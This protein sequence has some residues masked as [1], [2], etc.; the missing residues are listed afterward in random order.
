[1][2]Y[3]MR[4]RS[5]CCVLRPLVALAFLAALLAPVAVAQVPA[6]DFQVHA[7]SVDVIPLL[8]DVGSATVTVPWTYTYQPP[9]QASAAAASSL[10]LHWESP[11]CDAPGMIVTGSLSQV[12]S[13]NATP[14]PQS[15]SGESLFRVRASQDAPGERDITC[16]FEG[17][18][19]ANGVVPQSPPSGAEATVGVAF[20]GLLA[21]S[22]PV[23]ILEGGP[24]R[25][26]EYEVQVTNLGNSLTEARFEVVGEADGWVPI[27]PTRL[28]LESAN[29]NSP[30]K[31]PQTSAVVL[32][33]VQTPYNEGWNNRE[34]A[35]QLK[36][37]PASTRDPEQQGPPTTVNA[38]ARVRGFYC[39]TQET[40][41]GV[42]RQLRDECPAGRET[43]CEEAL[44]SLD[45]LAAE[46]VYTRSSPGAGLAF[47]GCLL[48]L[49]L[50]WR[51]RV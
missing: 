34:A 35:F 25:V 6:P 26:L 19:E 15:V 39:S 7:P 48:G 30:A 3:Y 20:R 38:L 43:Q 40:C 17:Y 47:M 27:V 31:E 49:A 46:G 23:T 1:M 29:G 32:F 11:T 44:T 4:R 2:A 36:V 45:A 50:V 14:P 41:E 33:K 22:V 16:R 10:T 8:T 12:V 18:V 24:Q 5:C 51:R 37:T 28:V 13:I 9:T 42:E 21:A